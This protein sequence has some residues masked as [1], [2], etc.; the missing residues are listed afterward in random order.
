MSQ[1]GWLHTRPRY[2]LGASAVRVAEG[3]CFLSANH[4]QDEFL[5][6]QRVECAPAAD[7]P[8]AAGGQIVRA[9][10]DVARRAALGG[11]A[12]LERALSLPSRRAARPLHISGGVRRGAQP[13]GV[14]A[15]ERR[16]DRRAACAGDPTQRRG[17]SRDLADQPRTVEAAGTAVMPGERGAGRED[18]GRGEHAPGAR[19]GR[20][21]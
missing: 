2:W 19:G 20:G 4:L 3:S 10:A 21:L 15:G 14:C 17:A 18:R 6:A 11:A 7:A 12:V 9:G 13:N 5:G 1:P 8:A 16:G